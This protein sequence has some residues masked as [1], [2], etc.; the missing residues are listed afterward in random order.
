MNT[1]LT[2]AASITA[3][4]IFTAGLVSA[5]AE[6][7]GILANTVT[8]RPKITISE[9]YS[10]RPASESNG[11]TTSPGEIKVREKVAVCIVA[12]VEG[13]DT[14]NLD[15]ETS[16]ILR[17]GSLWITKLL[18]DDPSYA[19]G[20][21]QAIFPFKTRVTRSNGSSYDKSLGRL[22]CV[23]NEDR[24]AITLTCTDLDAATLSSISSRGH[25]GTAAPGTAVAVGPEPV[26]VSVH[27]GHLRGKRI[28]YV[29]GSTR[30][31]TRHLRTRDSGSSRFDLSSVTLIGAADTTSPRITIRANA[32]T[33]SLRRVSFSGVAREING[34]SIRSIFVNSIEAQPSALTFGAPDARGVRTW[35]VDNLALQ[36]GINDV[37]LTFSDADGNETA[38]FP[39]IEAGNP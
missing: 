34:I 3:I 38:I 18:K 13:I 6:S 19:I 26:N 2:H 25:A 14:R 29:N 24:L 39:Q 15:P 4:A 30:T 31:Q 23:W 12:N 33:D 21:T 8:F 17:V 11:R 16:V 20:R 22:A 5:R 36:P 35:S 32:T 10:E 1:K 27:F 37:A 7:E 9:T 28:A